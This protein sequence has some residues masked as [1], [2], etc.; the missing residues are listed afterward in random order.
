M[1]QLGELTPAASVAVSGLCSSMPLHM[2]AFIQS[3][4]LTLQ[5]KSHLLEDSKEDDFARRPP[6]RRRRWQIGMLMFIVANLVGS[7]IQI[8][9]LPL[10]VLSTLQASGLVFNTICA[11]IILGEPFTKWSLG[12]TALVAGGALLIAL[13][14]ALPEPSHSLDQ[15]LQLL[16]R[17][18]FIVWMVCTFITIAII[19]LA[20]LYLVRV[21]RKRHNQHHHIS[22]RVRLCLGMSFGAVSAIL[23]SHSLLVAKSAVELLVRT[24]VDRHN[25][26]NR[27]Q[28]WLI[29]LTLLA[30]ALSQLFFLH[31]GLKLVSTSVLYPFVFCIYNIIAIL[32]GLIYFHQTD[33]LPPLHAGLITL[34]TVILLAG[35]LALSW[36]LGEEEDVAPP[37]DAH[38]LL[39]PGMGI[40]EDTTTDDD[41]TGTA[42]TTP[43]YSDDDEEA[44]SRAPSE[45]TPL[46][47]TPKS[48]NGTFQIERQRRNRAATSDAS[49]IL[50]ALEDRPSARRSSMFATPSSR[51]GSSGP[52]A[53]SSDDERPSS[54]L[55][56]RGVRRA[57]TL[58]AGATLK[59]GRDRRRR[60]SSARS[61]RNAS[62]ASPLSARFVPPEPERVA[63][64]RRVGSL[65]AVVLDWWR[66]SNFRRRG[67]NEAAANEEDQ[68][69]PGQGL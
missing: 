14:G 12:G 57:K 17:P 8:T 65:S 9:T 3:I 51:P 6:Y 22:P 44:V 5:R 36:R 32:D 28:S 34:G 61:G 24:I 58:G 41:N 42:S 50:D 38:N 39:T 53:L 16:A 49:E 47:K 21:S 31:K 56:A 30:L 2:A 63:A 52:G 46:L 40:I 68:D 25:Q 48:R 4:G 33:R 43:E 69:T 62:T 29:L 1:G 13:F 55:T 26:F 10:P 67:D 60:W 54:P 15:L 35:V 37:P 64:N 11:T 20:A 66:S 27:F 45:R 59:S 23:S 18:Q 19:L 7:T